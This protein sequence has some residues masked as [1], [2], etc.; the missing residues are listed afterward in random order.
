MQRI[1]WR[2]EDDH[3]HAIYPLKYEKDEMGRLIPDSVHYECQKCEGH[4]IN[5]DK[6][7]FLQLGEWR[8]TAESMEVG[9][10]SYHIST[11][12]SPI[13]QQSW[14][15]VCQ[16][17]LDTREGKEIAKLRVF[18]NQVLGE[19]FEER[20][21]APEAPMI[22]AR[23]EGYI[24]ERLIVDDAG[25]VT[26]IL[27]VD[28]P[29]RAVICTIG[30]DIQ[31]DRIECEI[32][33]W[34]R[35][36]ESWS[37]GY[38]ILPGDTKQPG[39]TCWRNLA[40]LIT[41]RHAGMQVFTALID[42][43]FLAPQA[44]LFCSRIGCALPSK[45]DDKVGAS[46][47][48]YQRGKVEGSKVDL[49]RLDVNFLKLEHYSHLRIG[50]PDG[51]PPTTTLRGYCHFPLDYPSSHYRQ[52][53]AEHQVKKKGRDGKTRWSWYLPPGRRNEALD[54]RVYALGALF[55]LAGATCEQRGLE[56]LDW[57]QFWNDADEALLITA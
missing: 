18:V 34:G 56:Q 4:W 10:R 29:D 6:A 52:I 47:K 48:I 44:Y 5:S 28:R 40:K 57:V 55:V 8:P 11:L 24:A 22:E 15:S 12:Y 42:S 17:W 27:E 19:S 1:F 31:I 9:F 43:G 53:T 7:H 36:K 25:R 14:E 23:K 38:H 26:D 33:A 13:G 54:C 45:G 20:G 51:K 41:S 3:G 2:I 50:P 32:V 16:R 21:D 49:V 30:V 37:L 39:D 46:R 35:D